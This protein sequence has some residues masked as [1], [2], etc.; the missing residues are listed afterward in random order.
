[1]DLG[2]L[3]SKKEK[4]KTSEKDIGSKTYEEDRG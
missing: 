3:V 1:M 4:D 2:N